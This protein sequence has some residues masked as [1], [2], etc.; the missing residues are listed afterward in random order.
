M[1]GS[2]R[3]QQLLESIKTSI[4]SDNI[5]LEGVLT[6]NEI[7]YKVWF[8]YDTIIHPI[9]KGFVTKPDRKNTNASY[10]IG[11]W[12]YDQNSSEFRL[13]P[14]NP[15]DI[16]PRSQT[17]IKLILEGLIERNTNSR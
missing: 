17:R 12:T 16:S 2:S 11:V 4:V 9:L 15:S 10:V 1:D 5:L 8:C 3:Y 6:D 13:E 14:R 7:V